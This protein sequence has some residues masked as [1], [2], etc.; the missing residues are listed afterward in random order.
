MRRYSSIYFFLRLFG[1]L[2]G[3]LSRFLNNKI[4]K[5]YFIGTLALFT[6]LIVALAKPYRKPFM[7]YLDIFLLTNLTLLCYTLSLGSKT[8]YKLT[9]ILLA[10]PLFVLI[11]SIIL[12]RI[13]EIAVCKTRC[14]NGKICIRLKDSYFKKPKVS[15]DSELTHE[16]ESESTVPIDSLTEEAPLISPTRAVVC[17]GARSNNS[18]Y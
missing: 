16:Q 1:Y 15:S 2:I 18:L 12:K 9:W 11:F 6:T 3:Y 13:R 14:C 4:S 8:V 5:L 17:Y 10:L 7:N